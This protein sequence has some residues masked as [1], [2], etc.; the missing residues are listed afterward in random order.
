MKKSKGKRKRP[1]KN[2][3]QVRRR[4]IRMVKESL[5]DERGKKV[6]V[7]EASKYISDVEVSEEIAYIE[8][9]GYD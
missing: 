8:G 1:S 9:G 5:E 7:K 3:E 6:S 4:L 2:R